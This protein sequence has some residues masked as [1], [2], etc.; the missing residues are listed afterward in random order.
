MALT[1]FQLSVCRLIARTRIAGGESYVA[2]G[3]ALNALA[4]AP[5]VSRYVDLFHDTAAAVRASWVADR[6][7]LQREGYDVRPLRERESFVQAV[8][9]RDP[10]RLVL[11]WT[12]DSAFRFFPLLEHS[13]FGLVL[14]P[15]DLAT[16]KVLALV[17]RL[18]PRDWVDVITCH[19]RIQPLGYLAFAACGKD[20][21]FGPAAILEQA[22]RSSRYSE[23]EI[24][25]LAFESLPPSAADLSR[26]WHRMLEEARGLVDLLPAAQAGRCV[27]DTGGSLWREPAPRL[28]EALA[29]GHLRFHPGCIR[30][31]L[32][33]P[34]EA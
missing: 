29:R 10:D 27:L 32:P 33:R 6:A 18:E 12:A 11:E 28:A 22:A 2:G 9:A 17:G 21:G 31:A 34:S 24:G 3:A 20:P 13:D 15:F 1:A 19:E 25:A 7:L 4:Q 23:V 30:G 16:N 5:R 8:V 14:H 26:R